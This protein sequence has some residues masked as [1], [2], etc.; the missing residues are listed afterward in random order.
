MYLIDVSAFS[1]ERSAD[2]RMNRIRYC[3]S[4]VRA[5][6]TRFRLWYGMRKALYKDIGCFFSYNTFVQREN[7][8]CLRSE[9]SDWECCHSMKYW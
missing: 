3:G 5:V 4:L 7:N 2:S 6:M 1:K 9:N 8:Y